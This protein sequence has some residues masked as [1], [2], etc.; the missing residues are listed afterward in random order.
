MARKKSYQR[1]TVIERNYD[2]GMA[3]V[4]RYRVRNS[5]G[6]W[7]EKSE[8]L[9][10][11]RTKKA[12]MKELAKRLESI[13]AGNGG[14]APRAGKRFSDLFVSDW[15]NYLDN[16]GVKPSTRYSYESI[17]KKW[18]K[19]FFGNMPLEEITPST[20]SKFMASLGSRGLSPKYRRNVYNLLKLLFDIAVE[21]DFIPASPIRPK[22]HRPKVDRTEKPIF[23]VAQAKAILET[24]DPL[25]RPLLA[26]L[27]MTGIRAGELLGLRWENIDFLNKRI[28]I[29][30]SLWRGVIQTTKTEAS[31]RKIGMPNQ[32]MQILRGHRKGSAFTA[33]DDFVFCQADG[34][35]I[36]PD[37]LRRNGIYPALAKAGVPFKKRA[38]GCHAFRHLAGSIIHRETGSL[39]LAQKQ[40]G[41]SNI[42]T[43]GDIYTHVED[44]E[45]DEPASILGRALGESVVD[46]WYAK[47]TRSTDV[48]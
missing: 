2:Y 26:T 5:E 41:H 9:K 43:T 39:K 40:L 4:L 28:V 33:P 8:T 22:V 15:P 17:L 7:T 31:D 44:S 24:A 48:Q 14:L 11:C 46:L 13:N 18:I 20:V 37:S 16:A 25:Y 23:S 3:Y 29:T 6:G 47:E 27:A 38:S 36:D 32:L 34:R 35:P 21:Y 1:G 42:S 45:M 30:Q 19:P 12:A 10:D